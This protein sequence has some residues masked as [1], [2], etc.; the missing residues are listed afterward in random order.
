MRHHAGL[1]SAFALL[2]AV[3]AWGAASSA[4]ADFYAPHPPYGPSQVPPGVEFGYTAYATES[5]AP[6]SLPGDHLLWRFEW[7]L[8]GGLYITWEETVVRAAPNDRSHQ[9]T[10]VRRWEQDQQGL[11]QVRFMVRNLRNGVDSPWSPHRNVEVNNLFIQRA[12]QNPMWESAF[13]A[14][15]PGEPLGPFVLNV[16]DLDNDDIV[17]AQFDWGDAPS[18]MWASAMAPLP[19]WD[20]GLVWHRGGNPVWD[21]ALGGFI[22]NPPPRLLGFHAWD[23]PGNFQVRARVMDAR[24]AVSPWSPVINVLVG[25]PNPNLPPQIIGPWGG[26]AVVGESA[27]FEYTFVDPNGDALDVSIDF[28]DGTVVRRSYPATVG[29]N[30]VTETFSHIWNDVA[31]ALNVGVYFVQIRA[32][33]SHGATTPYVLTVSMRV[34]QPPRTPNVPVGPASG[35]RNAGYAYTASFSDPERDAMRY[36]F[37]W[38]DGSL[39]TGNLP[40][41]VAGGTVLTSHIWS[42]PGTYAVRVRAVDSHGAQSAWSA[43]LNVTIAN[44][45]PNTP[46]APQGP[47]FSFTGALNLFRVSTTDPD[48]DP[49]RYLIVW[50]DGRYTITGIGAS[51]ATLGATHAYAS[52]GTYAVRVM[53]RDIYGRNSLLSPAS[54][55]RIVG[56]GLPNTPKLL[57]GG[58]LL[59]KGSPIE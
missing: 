2:C 8:N 13:R 5:G 55:I 9:V 32:T 50:G 3:G 52:P 19:V 48:G 33:D 38:G 49:M 54:S 26:S 17:W 12:P 45:A 20:S 29:E 58:L 34:N 46:P 31:H 21:S 53:A 27:S 22:R 35:L 6:N 18:P 40:A 15:V 36:T 23:R 42:L 14:G 44:R 28:Q 11:V 30:R 47:A 16:Q 41:N 51:G 25:N 43:P 59:G 37:D 39:T 1:R 56:F 4:F 10:A 24:R 7:T 57:G